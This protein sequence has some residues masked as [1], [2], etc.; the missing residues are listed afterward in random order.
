MSTSASLEEL[1]LRLAA[2]EDIEAIESLKA[3]YW[4]AIDRK[5]PDDVA[6]CLTADAIIDFEGLP[7]FD[8]RDEFMS[9]VRGA[10]ANACLFNMHHGQNPS[11]SLTGEHSATGTWEIFYYGIDV[12]AGTLVQM[13]GAYSDTY[14]R[15]NGHWL[16]AATAMRQTSLMVQTATP[17]LG[18]VVLGRTA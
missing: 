5:L 3:R 18:V 17:K 7:R 6:A 8:S 15:R 16:I 10:A 2:L 1:E 14:V 9:V 13:A 12:K 4:R 11:I